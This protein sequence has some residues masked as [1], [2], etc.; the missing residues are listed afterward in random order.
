VIYEYGVTVEEAL[1]LPAFKGAN[2]V[3]G[4]KGRF[5]VIKYVDVMEV[6]DAVN[7]VREQEMLLTTAYAIKNDA[8]AQEDLIIKLAEV[9]A[10]ALCIKPGRFIDRIPQK[11]INLAEKLDFPVI[12]LPPEVPY[13]DIINQVLS[14][15]LSKKTSFLETINKIHNTLTDAVLEGGGLQAICSKLA[16]LTGNPIAIFSS[17]SR[18]IAFSG[19]QG[20][21]CQL[22]DQL[23]LIK[24][25][26][27]Y[28]KC[29]KHNETN[30]PSTRILESERGKFII[31]PIVI[32]RRLYGFLV[33]FGY[34][35]QDSELNIKAL[36]QGAVVAALEFLKDKNVQ[37]TKKR[38]MKDL[39]NDL[40]EGNISNP[41]VLQERGRYLGWD[42]KKGMQVMVADIEERHT[43][44][45]GKEEGNIGNVQEFKNPL[46]DI[47]KVTV[48]KIDPGSIIT[49]KSERVVILINIPDDYRRSPNNL[50]S[51][52]KGIAVN[53]QREV[54]ANLNEVNINLGIGRYYGDIQ[55]ISKGYKEA[56]E[57]LNL[58]KGILGPGKV[59]HFDDLGVYKVMLDV[60]DKRILKNFALKYLQP[61]I[62]YDEQY[63]SDLITTLEAYL[64]ND[65]KISRTADE[66]FIHRNT[67]RYRIDRINDILGVDL[68][69]GEML[70]NIYF[71]LKAL[72]VIDSTY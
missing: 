46:L 60:S 72:K 49:D 55:N 26:G 54:T 21:I 64:K 43:R 68:E 58:G 50:Y 5:K 59:V 62:D 6:P 41:D 15:I 3:A 33:M 2:L 70:F 29:D 9:K 45:N 10:S 22:T 53:I 24:E 67:V 16:E 4:E 30:S 19:K 13:I 47:V 65:K 25:Y 48:K 39:I 7:W 8:K 66:L 38:I 31:T 52:T 28:D 51:Y 14:R 69:D 63:G 35:H 40:L 37:E 1:K 34:S 12:E 42:L 71:S 18:I 27:R 17:S 20:E 56:L 57:A 61:L 44:Y 23:Q 11:I 36:E 32:E